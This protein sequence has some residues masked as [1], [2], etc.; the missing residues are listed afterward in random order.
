MVYGV[1]G[2]LGGGKSLT[3]VRIM[4]DALSRGN[5]VTSN[6][7]LKDDYLRKNHIN[8]SNYTFLD[9][10][11]SVDPWT[12]RAGDFRGSGGKV[13]SLIVID[14]AGE[15]LDSYN[16][17]RHKGQLSDIASWLR[18]S[19]KLGQDVYFIVQFENLL[20]NRLRSIVHFW[21]VCQDFAKWNLPLI[22]LKIPF[23]SR[24]CV[25]SFF[26]GKKRDCVNRLWTFKGR[27]L[28]D[29]YDTSAFFGNSSARFSTSSTLATTGE[30]FNNPFL[31]LE[32]VVRCLLIF[33]V[34]SLI[35]LAVAG[36]HLY[37]SNKSALLKN[38]EEIEAGANVR[39]N[40]LWRH[41]E[42]GAAYVE[43]DPQF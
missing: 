21:V 39:S 35:S 26:D 42:G 30:N 40:G 22:P 24:F 28:Y 1:T 2:R 37:K 14:E 11:S 36:F 33:G 10:F 29:A 15:W 13:R 9:D 17:A 43:S 19:D 12:L 4:L 8:A 5:Y 32:T 3:C 16:D 18:Q 38:R 6:I 31:K 7:R 41:A 23:L 20:H 25:A 27:W 34:F